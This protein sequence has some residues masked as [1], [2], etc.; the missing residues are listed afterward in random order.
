LLLN[1]Y[2][3]RFSQIPFCAAAAASLVILFTPES[4]VPTAPPGTDKVV[5]VLLFAALATTGRTAG[6]RQAPLVIG[7]VCYAGI[8]EVLQSWL[9]LGRSGDLIDAAVDVLGIG[10]GWA[11]LAFGRRP[12][13][14]R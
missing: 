5:H 6:F 1:P 2:R 14:N 12:T 9:P 11:V 4:G 3:T 7:L 10:A 13:I 8:S